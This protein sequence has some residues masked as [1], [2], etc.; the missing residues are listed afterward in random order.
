MIK[1]TF[2]LIE[3]QRLLGELIY[4]S[5]FH[6][7]AEIKLSNSETYQI[8][9]VGIFRTTTVVTKNGAAI[10]NL[11]MNWRGQ[12]LIAFQYGQEYVLKGKGMFYS[13]YIIEN[14][15]QEKLMEL[16]PKFNWRKFRY[17]YNITYNKIPED[18]L[19][20]LLGIYAANYIINTIAS[21]M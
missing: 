11:K 10:A 21:A 6:S 20:I 14:Q 2:Q 16:D 12:M 4:E 18:T 13:K 17:N 8:K 5:L 19:L 7:K 15:E 1:K 3:N 9:P